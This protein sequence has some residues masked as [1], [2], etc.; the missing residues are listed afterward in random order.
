MS[1][2]SIFGNQT[3]A[4]DNGA[5]AGGGSNTPAT[6]GNDELATLLASIKTESGE[7]KYRTVQ[8]GLK[9][10]QHSQVFIDQLKNEMSSIRAENER[11]KA[12]ASKIAT[13]EQSVQELLKGSQQSAPAA[14]TPQAIDEA[15]IASLVQ[16]TISESE[17]KATREKNT[18][19]VADKLQQVFGNEAPTKFYAKAQELGFTNA[20][21]NDL[22]AKNPAVVFQLYGINASAPA[23]TGTPS[24]S[25]INPA[26]FGLNS[27]TNIKANTKSVLLGATTSE[28][29][30]ESRAARKLV[31]ELH[32]AGKSVHELTDPRVYFQTF[33]R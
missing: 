24:Q 21:I 22:A 25:S 11:L 12:E 26:G 2:P 16:K 14:T 13:L 4:P 20:E 10:L 15:T 31:D 27:D 33:K 32:A 29:V 1:D 3:T 17:A 18:K 5:P 9:A 19:L 30:E 7:A 23:P 8:D 28:V 6:P